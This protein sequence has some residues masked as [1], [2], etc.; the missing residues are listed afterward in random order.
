MISKYTFV[1]KQ[2][3]IDYYAIARGKNKGFKCILWLEMVALD[4]H[5]PVL[6]QAH[7]FSSDI[8][9]ILV[10]NFETTTL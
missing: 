9:D 1:L 5:L 10:E 3:W 7:A 8:S 6:I 4:A 2:A